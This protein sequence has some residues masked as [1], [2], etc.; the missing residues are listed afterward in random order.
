MYAVDFRLSLMGGKTFEGVLSPYLVVRAF[1]GPVL[2]KY[3]GDYQLG[4][5]KYH[6]QVGGGLVVAL[7]AHFDVYAEGVPLGERSAVVGMGY[8]F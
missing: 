8:S 7:P 2:W 6:F 5:D 3:R 4:G 1:G